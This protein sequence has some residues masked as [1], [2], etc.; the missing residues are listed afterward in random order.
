M[1]SEFTKKSSGLIT[2]LVIFGSYS[3]SFTHI[4]NI[5]SGGPILLS[6]YSDAVVSIITLLMALYVT[7][8]SIH[9]PKNNTF[10]K[11]LLAITLLTAFWMVSAPQ[12]IVFFAIFLL[13]FSMYNFCQ[14]VFCFKKILFFVI[15]F[16]AVFLILNPLG[17]ML[18]S[19]D[20]IEHI[21]YDGL[22]S[23]DERTIGLL[24]FYP[25][26]P[27]FF[28][29]SLTPEWGL[30]MFYD[31]ANSYPG[32]TLSN[33]LAKIWILEEILSTSIRVLFFPILG[34]AL[35]YY[36]RNDS[37]LSIKSNGF[38][39]T[40]MHI[41][42]LGLGLLS[43]GILASLFIGPVPTK[44]QLTRFL[45]PGTC[46]GMLCLSLTVSKLKN[47]RL[48]IALICLI[49]LGPISDYLLTVTS[50]SIEI[51]KNPD[52]YKIFLQAGPSIMPELCKK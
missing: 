22:M 24:H 48:L 51:F 25:G 2:S 38:N 46:I 49:N 47:R 42:Y 45:I 32:I 5:D 39:L 10:Y 9:E 31:S 7:F 41:F 20:F 1:I 35:L 44:W 11:P 37:Q 8:I 15:Q 43:L 40:Q 13:T 3:F 28:G 16:I 36:R 17:G 33:I 18:A 30:K 29:Y 50:N 23:F 26:I 27:F 12:N 19:K 14:R 21:N 52:K 6:G 34:L 4:V